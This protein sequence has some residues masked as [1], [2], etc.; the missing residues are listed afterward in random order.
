MV[1]RE[2]PGAP[3]E[4]PREPLLTQGPHST[5]DSFVSV[6]GRAAHFVRSSTFGSFGLVEGRAAHLVRS[7]LPTQGAAIYLRQFRFCRR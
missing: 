5:F 7:L 3:R 2:L 1:T 4:L 6:E